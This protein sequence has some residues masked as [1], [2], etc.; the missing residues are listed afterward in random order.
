MCN[1]DGANVRI[2]TTANLKLG[3]DLDQLSKLVVAYSADHTLGNIDEVSDVSRLPFTSPAVVDAMLDQNY[4]EARHQLAFLT[5]S[6]RILDA[7]I[8]TILDVIGG[9]LVCLPFDVTPNIID[10]PR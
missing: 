8:E 3:R 7:E 6:E 10:G 9:E 4:L 1:K 2:L 5:T